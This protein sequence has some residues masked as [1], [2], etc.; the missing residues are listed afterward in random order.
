MSRLCNAVLSVRLLYFNWSSMSCGCLRSGFLS[1]GVVGWSALRDCGISLA[2][3]LTFVYMFF[4]LLSMITAQF[5]NQSQDNQKPCIYIH[6]APIVY[7]LQKLIQK[8]L[9]NSD[10]NF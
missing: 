10:A 2:Y 4:F 1:F 6:T 3:S 7:M 5:S 8:N 9:A